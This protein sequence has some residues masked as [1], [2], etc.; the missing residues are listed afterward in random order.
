MARPLR[1][2]TSVE[3]AGRCSRNYDHHKGGREDGHAGAQEGLGHG[4]VRG[5]P[6]R[7]PKPTV[8]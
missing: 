1:A 2:E 6:H 7:N 4:P 5:K 3:F 8:K